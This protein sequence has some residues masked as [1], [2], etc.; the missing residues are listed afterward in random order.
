MI[1][2]RSSSRRGAP[3]SVGVDPKSADD[4]LAGALVSDDQRVRGRRGRRRAAGRSEQQAL[5]AGD[6]D[7]L[8]HLLAEDHVQRGDEGE[9]E[10][11]EIASAA[12]PRRAAEE[13]LDQLGDRRLAEE[14]DPDRGQRDA[15]LGGGDELVD[16]VDLVERACGAALASSAIFSIRL[17]RE[18]TIANSAATK[19]PLTAT[20]RSRSSRTGR[21]CALTS[22]LPAVSRYFGGGRRLPC[23]VRKYSFPRRH[24]P[25]RTFRCHI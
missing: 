8:R 7:H 25:D 12:S 2:S 9:G 1:I 14:A 17:R 10:G 20:R 19:K 5:G 3:R 13:G 18:R 15:D 24:H 23:G 4:E 21:T 22:G 16:V 6:P 11:D